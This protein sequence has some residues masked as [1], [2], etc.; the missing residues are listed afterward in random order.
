MSGDEG[1]MKRIMYYEIVDLG[2][3][4]G[5]GTPRSEMLAAIV[6]PTLFNGYTAGVG[7]DAECSG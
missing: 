5:M 3:R 4:N 6:N 1:I 2:I 7:T